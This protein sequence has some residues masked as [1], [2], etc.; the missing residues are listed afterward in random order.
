M[1]N[2]S[3]VSAAILIAVAALLGAYAWM[4]GRHP[5][6]ATKVVPGAKSAFAVVV[7]ARRLPAGHPIAADAVR[8]EKLSAFPSG[9]FADPTLVAKRIPLADIEPETPVFEGQLSSGFADRVAPGERAVA[10][11][12]DEAGAVSDLVRPG[13]VVDVFLTLKRDGAGIGGQGEIA[14][15]QAKLLL[16]HVRVLAFGD[17]PPAGGGPSAHVVHARTVVLAVPTGDV[18]RLA[19]ADSAGH[20]L[21][22]LRNPHD[23]DVE[24]GSPGPMLA[25]VGGNAARAARPSMGADAGVSLGALSGSDRGVGSVPS[26]R[27]PATHRG[28]AGAGRVEVVR[29]GH[30]GA[31]AP[32]S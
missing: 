9:A 20:L 23:V 25:R 13:N 21:L 7:A 24:Q 18:D 26:A 30:V 31:D 6:N 29:A 22:A 10:V 15:S 32:G 27:G 5:P 17:A 28:V 12:V 19:L 16:S 1:L 2:F 4:L 3:K 11:R 8:I 14:R